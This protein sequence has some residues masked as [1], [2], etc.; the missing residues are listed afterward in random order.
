MLGA[1]HALEGPT[2]LL[3]RV[4]SRFQ[5]LAPWKPFSFSQMEFISSLRYFT[6]SGSSPAMV[7]FLCA[8]LEACRFP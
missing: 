5:C 1:V 7:A 8:D 3:I 4:S 2:Y 6:L